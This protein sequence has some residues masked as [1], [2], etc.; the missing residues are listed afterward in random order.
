VSFGARLRTGVPTNIQSPHLN[1]GYNGLTSGPTNLDRAYA[2]VKYDQLWAWAGKNSFPL[3]KQNELFWDDDVT[4]SG[5]AAGARLDLGNVELEPTAAFFVADHEQTVAFKDG[6]IIAAQVKASIKASDLVTLDVASAYIHM[7]RIFDVPQ[8]LGGMNRLEY[9]FL[10]NNVRA[11]IDIGRPLVFGVDYFV[12]LADYDD[13]A[14]V[15]DHYKD[16]KHG[17]VGHAH[18]GSTKKSGDFLV[19]YYFAYKQ[20]YSVVDYYT[21]DD[22]VRWGNVDRNRNTNYI[23]HELRLA[24]TFGKKLNAVF[25]FYDVTAIK[26]RIENDPMA[27]TETGNRVRLDFNVGF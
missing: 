7:R 20:R 24:Y 16:Q 9:Q 18:Y 5:V 8:P 25:R 12:N 17:F 15:A 14:F 27:V 19:G 3:W 26:A 23:G 22:W 21:E 2:A 6:Q 10:V 1:V 11:T 13:V 4:P